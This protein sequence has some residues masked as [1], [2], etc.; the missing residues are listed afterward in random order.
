MSRLQRLFHDSQSEP[1]GCWRGSSRG[2]H[3]FDRPCATGIS[4]PLNF[5][6]VSPRCHFHWRSPRMGLTTAGEC[7][8]HTADR[9]RWHQRF[10]VSCKM[11]IL[12]DSLASECTDPAARRRTFGHC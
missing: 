3:P 6:Y 8:L 5:T 10:T 7:G 1:V 4:S 9:T 11:S 12:F 2:S